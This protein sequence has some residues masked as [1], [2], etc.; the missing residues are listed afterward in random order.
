MSIIPDI[1]SDTIDGQTDSR[2]SVFI[3]L[4]DNLGLG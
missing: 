3:L 4:Q 1:D 2:I